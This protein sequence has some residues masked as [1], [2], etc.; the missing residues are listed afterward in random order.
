M[1]TG[2]Q[3]QAIEMRISSRLDQVSLLSVCAR[4]LAI[5][6]NFSEKQSSEIELAVTEA[7][8]NVI[9]HAYK[10]DESQPIIMRL[11]T[12]ADEMV[13]EVI[14]QGITPPETLLKSAKTDFA[15]LPDDI[16]K[17][18]ENGRGLTLILTMMDEVEID[19]QDNWNIFRMKKFC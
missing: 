12:T 14:D 4:A 2:N 3:T 11:N 16:Y 1:N 6:N 8:T 10:E 9:E 18:D 13:I 17:I 7:V 19:L 15:E 5:L